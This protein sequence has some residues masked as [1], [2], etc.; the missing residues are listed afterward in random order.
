MKHILLVVGL[1]YSFVGGAGF[2]ALTLVKTPCDW[3]AIEQLKVGDLVVCCDNN[4]TYVE[5]VITH[6][7]AYKARDCMCI[8]ID[9]ATIVTSR[10]HNFYIFDQKIWKMAQ[11]LKEGDLLVG[12]SGI[13]MPI[14]KITT[15]VQDVDLYDIAVKDCHNFLVSKNNILV[16]NFFPAIAVALHWAVGMGAAEYMGVTLG[17][18]G[19]RVGLGFLTAFMHRKWAKDKQQYIFEEEMKEK[20]LQARDGQSATNSVSQSVQFCAPQP[21]TSAVDAVKEVGTAIVVAGVEAAAKHS[22]N[23]AQ[24]KEKNKFTGKS[25]GQAG[26]DNKDPKCPFHLTCSQYHP[27]GL[28]ENAGYHHQNSGGRK[29]PAPIDGQ[30]ALDRSVQVGDDSTSYRRIGVSAGQVVILMRTQVGLWHGYVLDFKEARRDVQNI[31]K[32]Q[33]WTDKKGKIQCLD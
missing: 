30:L 26:T 22:I 1:L 19:L 24:N 18:G 21:T 15:I 5:K 16:H 28:Y 4:H 7:T 25:Q 23:K 27:H 6:T 14:Q 29:S 17:V 9:G 3:V 2:P 20:G 13:G 31:L 8:C 12:R 32:K 11:D 33:G 10:Y